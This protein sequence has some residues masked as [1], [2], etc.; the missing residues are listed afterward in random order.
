MKYLFCET[1]QL[2][3]DEKTSVMLK[4]FLWWIVQWKYSKRLRLNQC[5]KKYFYN[6]LQRT[7]SQ[8]TFVMLVG[9]EYRRTSIPLSDKFKYT[10]KYYSVNLVKNLKY[11]SIID[12]NI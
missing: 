2:N 7:M 11:N 6:I 12:V 8:K 4:A 1:D 10:Y 5:F 9:H 3:M